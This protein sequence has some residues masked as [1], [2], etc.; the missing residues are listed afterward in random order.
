MNLMACKLE[1]V[2][3]WT[4]ELDVNEDAVVCSNVV[5]VVVE[6]IR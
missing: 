4:S 2:D 5:E 3:R 1:V 6:C